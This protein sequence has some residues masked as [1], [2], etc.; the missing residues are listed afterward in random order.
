[1]NNT[2]YIVKIDKDKLDTSELGYMFYKTTCANLFCG[3]LVNQN[4]GNFYFELNNSEDL[5][6][7]PHSWI[8]WMAPSKILK[9]EAIKNNEVCC[10]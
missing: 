3:R 2:Y 8:K 4:N 7:I 10:S 5:V 6:I 1:M 9:E